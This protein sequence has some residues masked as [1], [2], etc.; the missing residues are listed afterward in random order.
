MWLIYNSFHQ[1]SKL[2]GRTHQLMASSVT[3][4]QCLR[5]D[6]FVYGILDLLRKKL[7]GII[8]IIFGNHSSRLIFSDKMVL[9]KWVYQEFYSIQ[10]NQLQLSGQH[11]MKVIYS[12]LIGVWSQLE[13]V[14]KSN[15]SL[16]SMWRKLMTLKETTD[17][18]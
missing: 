5:M 7:L 17:Q 4:S 8:L 11:Q 1:V 16:L 2:T 3:L 18:F 9:E 6:W 10:N 12:L 13:V 15:R 14:E